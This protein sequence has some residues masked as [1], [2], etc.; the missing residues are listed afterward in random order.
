MLRFLLTSAWSNSPYSDLP[1]IKADAS[2]TLRHFFIVAG[3][4]ALILSRHSEPQIKAHYPATRELYRVLRSQ[5]RRVGK[6]NASAELI[7]DVMH[8]V[9]QVVDTQ[10]R[11]ALKACYEARCVFEARQRSRNEGP[12]AVSDTPMTQSPQPTTRSAPPDAGR[13]VMPKE[14]FADRADTL[15]RTVAEARR[16]AGDGIAS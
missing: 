14:L 1:E 5:L 15:R 2:E 9:S 7:S 11:L 4:L 8:E 10:T 6:T 13:T 12:G 16:G 3:G